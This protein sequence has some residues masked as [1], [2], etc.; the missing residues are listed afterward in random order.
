MQGLLNTDSISGLSTFWKVTRQDGTILGF[1]DWTQNVVVAGVTYEAASGYSRSAL[2][3]RVDLAVPNVDI[4][5]ILSSANITDADIRAGRYDNATVKIWMAVATDA[6]FAT[7]G[8]I[9]LPGAFLGE[10]KIQDGVYVAEIRG[11]AYALQQS[12]I[13]LF[14]PTCQA[15]FCDSRCQLS[16]TSFT[17]TGYVSG[18]I[19]PHRTFTFNITDVVATISPAGYNYGLLTWMSGKNNGLIVEITNQFNNQMSTAYPTAYAIQPGDGF[20]ALVGCR[21]VVSDCNAFNNL[22][23]YRGFPQIPGINFLLDYG[24][25]EP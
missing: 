2:Q 23:N 9:P 24:E 11:L 4:T 18:V 8:T 15:D 7:Y 12:F 21:K 5:G 22:V 14:S 20:T 17:D 1:T 3:Q 6:S 16:A 10:I 25:A 19:D 13:E